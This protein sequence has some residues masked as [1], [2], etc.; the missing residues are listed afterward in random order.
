MILAR[1]FNAKSLGAEVGER[2]VS[3]NNRLIYIFFAVGVFAASSELQIGFHDFGN[4]E[5]HV[6]QFVLL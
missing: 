3:I 2:L 6:A 5:C 4:A 1:R